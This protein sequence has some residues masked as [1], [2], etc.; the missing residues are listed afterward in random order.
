MYKM[1]MFTHGSIL[2][3]GELEKEAWNPHNEEHN[4]VWDEEGTPTMLKNKIWKPPDTSQPDGV[5]QER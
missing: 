4:K 2:A 1:L 5:A 3:D